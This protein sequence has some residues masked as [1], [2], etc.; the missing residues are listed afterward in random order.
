MHRRA[1]DFSRQ[2]GS[3]L[4]GMRTAGFLSFLLLLL[5]GSA[6]AQVSSASVNGVIRD[7]NGAVI[8]SAT[9]VLTSVDTSVE[10][11]SV[12]NG[13]GAYVFLDI[14]PGRYTVA[15]SAQGFNP[16]K[17]AEF[18]LAVSQIATYDFSLT[19]GT[20]TQVV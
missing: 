3:L 5:A 9:I 12:S 1:Q 17:F 20:Q 4:P 6:T 18:V 11:T 2:T 14:T 10:R 15:A 8:P 13:S 7:P 19:V 16:Q